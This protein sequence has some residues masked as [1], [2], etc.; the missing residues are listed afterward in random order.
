MTIQQ[1][2]EIYE[3]TGGNLAD[4]NRSQSFRDA[5]VRSIT[6]HIEMK[7]EI[8]GHRK[9]QDQPDHRQAYRNIITAWTVMLQDSESIKEKA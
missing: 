1:A 8:A 4:R 7:I 2:Q 6:R 3:L 5:L 9:I